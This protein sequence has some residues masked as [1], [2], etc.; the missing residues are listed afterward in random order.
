[1]Q[2]NPGFQDLGGPTIQDRHAP[3][4]L[5][6]R[7]ASVRLG[8]CLAV[9]IAAELWVGRAL[10]AP[11]YERAFRLPLASPTASLYDFVRH[12][13]H[14]PPTA[15]PK[16]AFLGASPTY[17]YRVKDARSTWPEAFEAAA[18]RAGTSVRAYN[19]ACNGQFLGDEAV[20]AERLASKAGVLYIQ[21]TYHTFNP[22]A[23]SGRALRFAE[24]PRLLAVSPPADEARAL[25][26]AQDAVA[27]LSASV[28]RT[29]RDAWA[30]YRER[31]AIDKRLFGGTPRGVLQALA[32]GRKPARPDSA[33]DTFDDGFTSFDSLDP[34]QQMVVVARYAE[35]ASFALTAEDSQVRLLG[36][37]AR[38]LKRRGVKAVF[39]MSPLNRDLIDAWEL[40][41][42]P[43]YRR[44]VGLL[45]GAVTASGFPFIDYNTGPRRF[46]GE[47]FADVSH[48][49]DAGAQA[50]GRA[51]F[52]DTR[53]YLV[54]LKGA[55]R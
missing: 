19:V 23:R 24:L 52:A 44:N 53:R 22:R 32:S 4:G 12:I 9:L 15:S 54:S 34:A 21:L 30:L 5:G 48:T 25:G 10:P 17:G 1:M 50:V 6:L 45:Q 51:L 49:T 43:Q 8:V 31:E 35:D 18:R 46:G 14:A 38:S 39:Y 16:I 55:A 47:L 40:I 28:D 27:P 26:L 7:R 11:D 42:A 20:V 36:A 2:V 41:D 33:S 3:R 29:L 13:E 37:L